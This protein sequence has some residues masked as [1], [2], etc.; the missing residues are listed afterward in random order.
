MVRFHHSGFFANG[1]PRR[2]W[3]IGLR[4]D[5]S[6]EDYLIQHHHYSLFESSNQTQCCA[7]H[8]ELDPNTP[9]VTARALLPEPSRPGIGWD[10]PLSMC[11]SL[12]CIEKAVAQKKFQMPAFRNVIVVSDNADIPS[13]LKGTDIAFISPRDFLSWK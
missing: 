12:D 8:K 9:I 6:L 3:I 11:A 2:P 5:M 7:C 1:R 10:A 4:E 13:T